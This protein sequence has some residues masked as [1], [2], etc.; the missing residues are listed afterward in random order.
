MTKQ[1]KTW[2]ELLKPHEHKRELLDAGDVIEVS[3]QQAK[4]MLDNNIAKASSEPK[5]SES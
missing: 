2:V 3:E 4:R 1:S 5:N